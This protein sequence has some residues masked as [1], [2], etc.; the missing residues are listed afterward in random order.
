MLFYLRA[1]IYRVIPPFYEAFADAFR[2]AYAAEPRLISWLRFGTWVGG[3]MDGNPNVSADTIRIGSMSNLYVNTIVQAN[4]GGCE[5][6]DTTPA[7]SDLVA[8]PAPSFFF[9]A[10]G[11]LVSCS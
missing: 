8:D 9:C 1:V 7:D 5:L 2:G 4:S 6:F 10:S 11:L 3:D